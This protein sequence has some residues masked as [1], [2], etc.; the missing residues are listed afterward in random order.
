MAEKPQG[1][2]GKKGRAPL[3]GSVHR[4]RPGLS[5]T[6][7]S[8]QERRFPGL[9][10]VLPQGLGV[11]KDLYG[12]INCKSTGLK[13]VKAFCFNCSPPRGTV[14]G[15][16]QFYVF[17]GRLERQRQ[18]SPVRSRISFQV[19]KQICEQWELELPTPGRAD[20]ASA[21]QRL[22]TCGPRR[23][24]EPA[25]SNSLPEGWG[26]SSR[27]QCGSSLCHQGL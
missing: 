25:W 19:A 27:G 4:A 13:K 18:Q 7:E 2:S 5:L 9:L 24:L 16:K 17:E 20:L 26:Q 8:S 11:Q 6:P 23:P 12:Q 3:P 14:A 21:G 15:P 22:L 10:P 1:H